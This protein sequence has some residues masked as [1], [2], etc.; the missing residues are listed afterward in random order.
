MKGALLQLIIL[1][2]TGGFV[3]AQPDSAYAR[4]F[5]VLIGMLSG[6]EA[7]ELERAVFTVENAYLDGALDSSMFVSA[8]D[9]LAA[10]A[11]AWSFANPSSEYTESDSIP[12]ALNRATFHVLTDT[13]FLAPGVPIGLPFTYDT[14]DFFGAQHWESTF[15]TKLLATGSGQC[16]SLPLLYAMICKRLGTQAYLAVVPNH[17]YV[18]QYSRVHGWYNIELT[19]GQFPD[20]AW[21][22]AT[23]YVSTDAVRSGLYMDTLGLRQTLALCLTDLAQGYQ[24]RTS[25]PQIDFTLRCC[26]AALSAHPISVH[27]L[28]LKVDALSRALDLSIN[29]QGYN[30]TIRSQLEATLEILIRADYR[31]VPFEVYQ[32]WIAQLRGVSG[33]FV[34]ETGSARP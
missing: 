11:R 19:S 24:R 20:D 14:V 10:L 33:R 16:H 34:Y 25:S 32:N 3:Q 7:A 5:D 6:Q 12:F 27:A 17:I 28:L 2:C 8:I 23:G 29:D 21:I 1:L 15:V 31:E 9:D 18:K 13:T 4:A 30:T 22:M 26:N